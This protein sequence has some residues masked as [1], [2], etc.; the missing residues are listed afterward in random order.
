MKPTITTV[1]IAGALLVGAAGGYRHGRRVAMPSG[2][3]TATKPAP[4]AGTQDADTNQMVKDALDLVKHSQRLV[5]S[6][7]ITLV[8][9]YPIKGAKKESR[10]RSRCTE[11]GGD[12][13]WRGG[14]SPFDCW[15]REPACDEFGCMEGP[16]LFRVYQVPLAAMY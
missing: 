7:E 11:F 2:G 8:T 12:V 4:N 9:E 15:S 14:W 16:L 13:H 3:E 6:V 5:K 10:L 1:L